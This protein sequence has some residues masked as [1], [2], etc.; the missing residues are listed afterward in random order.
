MND[1]RIKNSLQQKLLN[2]ESPVEPSDWQA[3]S[4]RL[5]GTGDTPEKSLLQSLAVGYEHPVMPADWDIIDRRLQQSKRRRAAAIWFTAGSAVAAA[6][7]LLLLLQPFAAQHDIPKSSPVAVIN[8]PDVIVNPE[9]VRFAKIPEKTPV[10]PV[11]TTGATPAK[12]PAAPAEPDA[13]VADSLGAW[14]ERRA[15]QIAGQK[16]EKPAR[17]TS[18]T[19]PEDSLTAFPLTGIEDAPPA[20]TKKNRW[21]IALLA[22]Q[23]GGIDFSNAATDLYTPQ[24]LPGRLGVR[25]RRLIDTRHSLPLSFGITFRYY[26]PSSHWALESGLVYT[27]L[28]SE[29]TYNSDPVTVEKKLHYIGVPVHVV[30]R[31]VPGRRVSCYLSGGGMIE[32][33][34]A[35][36]STAIGYE[37]IQ[38]TKM[39]GIDGLQWSLNGQVGVEYRFYKQFSF[40]FEPG[41]R[42]FFS[43]DG[44]PKSL[45]SDRPFTFIL[46]CGIRTSL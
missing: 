16:A 24:S 20:K 42:Y 11:N 30:Y 15:A 3:I 43:Y 40:Y 34:L 22:G 12:A 32:T 1:D 25:D 35:A 46:G 31:V 37:E 33:A 27:Y 36:D 23:A 6:V 26:I 5:N 41:V 2:Y 8:P 39:T 7:A 13:P 38:R 4:Q 19:A 44:Q 28:S 9:P 45:R 17:M 14:P 10:M 29:Y 21:A 18:S